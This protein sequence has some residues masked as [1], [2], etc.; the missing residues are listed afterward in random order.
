MS[1]SG[2]ARTAPGNRTRLTINP[3]DDHDPDW[4][5]DGEKLAFYSDRRRVEAVA[6]R[7]GDQRV[8][9][10]PSAA[11]LAQDGADVRRRPELV[12]GWSAGS[13][14]SQNTGGQNFETWT[15]L[16]DGTG[17]VNLTPIGGRN[18]FP[19]LGADRG[20]RR[21]H[22]PRSR[23]QGLRAP[24]PA[25]SPP[26]IAAIPLDAIRGETGS[27]SATPLGGIPLGGIPLGG[28]PL[29]RIPLGGIPLGGIGFT[30]QNLETRTG[31]VES[32]S[33]RFRS[34]CPTSGNT[35]RALDPASEGAPAAERDAGPGARD[36]PVVT[37]D[38][39]RRPRPSPSSPLGG[40][41]PRRHRARR[42]PARWASRSP[43]LARHSRNGAPM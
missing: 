3:A 25:P 11:I 15:A 1:F 35:P 6:D 12:A 17:Q 8:R 37:G 22:P 40:I 7:C 39:A 10:V 36:T 30:A 5:P 19:E 14:S 33:R 42:P 23:S 4:S 28:I 31:S 29:G 34:S 2:R 32:R 13:H 20:P 21:A 18:S 41:P 38:H 24:T 43:G 16:A 26:P 9:R 27:T